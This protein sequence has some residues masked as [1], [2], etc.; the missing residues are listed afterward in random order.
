M[1][2]FAELMTQICRL[3]AAVFPLNNRSERVTTRCLSPFP[4]RVFTSSTYAYL[5]FH[6][7]IVNSTP[8]ILQTLTLAYFRPI[9]GLLDLV[10]PHARLFQLVYSCPT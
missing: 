6:P 1:T 5:T 2:V 7:Y 4:F 9:L 8:E 10:F 3:L